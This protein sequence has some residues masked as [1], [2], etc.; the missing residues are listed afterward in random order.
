MPPSERAGGKGG[1]AAR[2]E[3]AAAFLLGAVLVAAGVPRLA[4]EIPVFDRAFG[5]SA[6]QPDMLK[7]SGRAEA[8]RRGLAEAPADPAAWLDLARLEN[9]EGGPAAMAKA[10]RLSILTGPREPALILPRL[11]LALPA[12]GS[13]DP[14]DRFLVS[15]QIRLAWSQFP[16]ALAVIGR[17]LD[18]VDP[19]RAALAE[20][21]GAAEAFDQRLAETPPDAVRS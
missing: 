8:V 4:A 17:R 1:T 12:W 10:L 21:P 18:A 14:D 15:E 9:A 13:L 7:A 5:L 6:A 16:R 19:I 11:E 20:L 3:L 2:G